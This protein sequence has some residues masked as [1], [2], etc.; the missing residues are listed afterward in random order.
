MNN[1]KYKSQ[2]NIHLSDSN[3]EEIIYHVWNED[4][5]YSKQLISN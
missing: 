4:N 3:L 5:I 1:N 2:Y